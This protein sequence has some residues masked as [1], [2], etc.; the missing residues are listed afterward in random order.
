MT[1]NRSHAVMAQRHEAH[2][3][4]DLFPTPPWAT[5]ALCEWFKNSTTIRPEFDNCWEPACGHG[6][7]SRTLAEYFN[8]VYATD[9]FDYGHGNRQDFLF[10]HEN[11]FDWIITNP[12][13]RLAERFALHGLSLARKGVALLVRT[14][15]LESAAR[16]DALFKGSS[17][18][19][20]LQFV[21]RVPMVKG[22]LDRGASSATA[23]CWLVWHASASL[24]STSKFHWLAPCRKRLERDSDYPA[25][26][27]GAA[28]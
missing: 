19:D 15:F 11:D 14:A 9:I 10:A 16:Y 23:Y 13:F 7:M 12:P 25:I 2:D 3:S 22:R 4:L 26:V 8:P 5:R 27:A 1:Q 24:G 6:D 28:A 17:P 20:I 18:S 21:E